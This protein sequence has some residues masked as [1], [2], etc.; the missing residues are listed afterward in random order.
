M[1]LLINAMIP[2]FLRVQAID[3]A[4]GVSN[5]KYI[6]VTVCPSCNG[7]G[8]CDRSLTRNEAQSGGKFRRNVCICNPA[9]TGQ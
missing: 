5:A 8:T 2:Y 6:N 4:N 9:Y 7:R 1:L 3:P